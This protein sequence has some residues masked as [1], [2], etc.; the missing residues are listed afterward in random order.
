MTRER[1]FSPGTAPLERFARGVYDALPKSFAEANKMFNPVEVL[2]EASGKSRRFFESGGKDRQAGIEA[3]I[4]TAMLGIGPAAYGVASLLRT[5]AK[6]SVDYATKA[7][8][9]LFNPL[10]ASDDRVVET[11]TKGMTRRDFLGGTGAGVILAGAPILKEVGELLPEK[12]VVKT[13]ADLFRESLKNSNAAFSRIIQLQDAVK[14]ADE[15]TMKASREAIDKGLADPLEELFIL[16]PKPDFVKKLEESQDVAV[17]VLNKN[18]SEFVKDLTREKLLK[19]SD[20]ELSILN[21]LK[22]V[23]PHKIDSTGN[24]S[25]YGKVFENAGEPLRQRYIY[26]PDKDLYNLVLDPE[27][28]RVS[29]LIDSVLI[30]RGLYDR[31]IGLTDDFKESTAIIDDAMSAKSDIGKAQGGVVSLRDEARNMFR[32][33]RGIASLTV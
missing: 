17:E 30:E 4:D 2:Q 10:G 32:K 15:A 31:F 11:G 5:P 23:S 33:P 27:S 7:F 1:Y 21:K 26:D 22:H 8:Q 16:K 3:L 24:F 6:K 13:S 12:G 28:K 20:Q 29:E 18:L 19:L 14:K 25:G 9:E